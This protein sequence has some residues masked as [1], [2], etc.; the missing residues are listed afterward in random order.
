MTKNDNLIKELY[1]VCKELELAV[2]LAINWINPFCPGEP[3][4]KI[5]ELNVRRLAAIAKVEKKLNDNNR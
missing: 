1:E 3:R 5:R 2:E 4:N